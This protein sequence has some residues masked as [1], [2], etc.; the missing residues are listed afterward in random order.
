M[1]LERYRG[2]ELEELIRAR[3]T[4][5]AWQARCFALRAA[6]RMNIAVS[7]ETFED[8]TDG[9][10]IRA[11]LRAGVPLSGERI[12][13]G[14]RKLMRT[15]SLDELMLGLEIAAYSDDES[16]RDE[17]T[18]RA[19]RLI[20]NMDESVRVRISDRLMR[21]F[22]PLQ[23]LRTVQDWQAWLRAQGRSMTLAKPDPAEPSRTPPE[24][25]FVAELDFDT[26][27]R[28]MDYLD[29]LRERE[30]DLVIVMD[31]TTSML[32]M[33]NE[34]R[35]GVESLILFLSDISRTM[36][37][38][39]IAYR[40]HDNPPIWE[41][42]PFTAD[43]ASIR[44]FL[45]GL[46]ITG[47][48]NLPEAVLAGITACQQLDWNAD[49]VRQIVLVGDARPHDEEE[50]MLRD[51][52]ETMDRAGIV[53]HAVHVPMVRDPAVRA[54]MNQAQAEA[55]R[56]AVEEHNVLTEQAFG[57]IARLGGG[58]KVTLDAAPDLVPSI[59]H[60]TIAEAWWPAFDEFYALY[61][62]L[63]R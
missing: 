50:Y 29:A 6:S 4:D 34:A 31:A 15:R 3:L 13:Q 54:G 16:I 38:A 27:G 23:E 28:L 60:L 8:E 7:P 9:R 44:N 36:R 26:Y 20:R 47:G 5:D 46:N 14:T 37:L 24:K 48:Y 56:Q 30:L 49:A 59:M 62:E 45:F 2:P 18:R 21:L 42:H 25:P 55:D 61:L 52:L 53:V 33:L 17:A 10:V 40:D 39:F 57:E 22:N 32:P 41:G 63:C 35:A 51:L 12:D 58:E 43:V 1:R 19:K 11:A